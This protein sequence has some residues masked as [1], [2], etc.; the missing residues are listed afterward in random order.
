[1]TA[2]GFASKLRVNF[3]STPDVLSSR[4][5]SGLIRPSFNA[6]DIMSMTECDGTDQQTVT[7]FK[8]GTLECTTDLVAREV[9][10][11]LVYNGISH[12]VMMCTPCDLEEFAIG[13]SL[14]EGIVSGASDLFDIEVEHQE[15]AAIIAVTI[16]Q[17]AFVRMKQ[18]RRALA[19]RTGCGVCGIESIELLDL[20][21][22]PVR[23]T[24]VA[25]TVKADAIERASR[26]MP[27]WQ[28]LMLRTGGV[29]AAA[30][31]SINGVVLEVTEDVGRHN[32]IDKLIGR[33]VCK[34][35]DLT[36][37]FVF[38]SSRASYELVRKI[39]RVD[40]PMIATVSAPTSLAIR[41][42]KEAR[43]RLLS[44]C[45][46]DGFVEYSR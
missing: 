23:D 41:L 5:A 44:F 26:E 29:H 12:A 28:Y 45:R 34:K 35:L 43:A 36:Q 19:V 16:A 9:P 17:E 27:E 42:A 37:G 31:C 46:R 33:L 7:R 6:S 13:F 14:T 11:S 4:R 40:I 24:N 2:R 18:G 21:P 30:W 3:M 20:H 25:H 1:V 39:A 32:A 22:R 15:D 8:S 10:V 38:L